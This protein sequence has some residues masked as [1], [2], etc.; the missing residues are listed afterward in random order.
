[1]YWVAG[2]FQGHFRYKRK[3]RSN[4]AEKCNLRSDVTRVGGSG[5]GGGGG[6]TI[7]VS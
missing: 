7:C 5:G 4:L 1:M 6:E 2:V 3:G